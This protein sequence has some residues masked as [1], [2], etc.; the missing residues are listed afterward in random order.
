MKTRFTFNYLIAFPRAK[1]GKPVHS[2]NINKML[3]GRY[4]LTEV[5]IFNFVNH[6]AEEKQM[7]SG[8][9]FSR[10]YFCNLPNSL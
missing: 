6:S 5:K 9:L 8:E 3:L 2:F 1:L 10:F 4:L 7:P